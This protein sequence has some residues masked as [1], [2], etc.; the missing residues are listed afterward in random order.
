MEDDR[1]TKLIR[2]YIFDE[3]DDDN[4]IID[5]VSPLGIESSPKIQPRKS[6][7]ASFK[8]P[9]KKD[10]ETLYEMGFKANLINTIYNNMHPND[11]QDAFIF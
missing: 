6:S 1:K 10:K 11:I 2:D 9:N 3:D 5:D 7:R 8:G 4:F